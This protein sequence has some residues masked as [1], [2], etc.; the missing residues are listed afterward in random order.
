MDSVEQDLHRYI[1]FGIKA[2]GGAGDNACGAWLES[3]LRAQGFAV[4][5][6]TVSVPFFTPTR[7]ELTLAG[8]SAPVIPQAIVVPTPEAG[9]TGRFARID[10]LLPVREELSDAIAL[11]DIPRARHSTALEKPIQ[12]GVKA[13]TAKGA[14]AAVILTN[15]PT[16]QAV[17]L[18]ADGNKPMF[19]IPVAV[20]APQDA[21][22][23]LAAAQQGGS[24]TLFMTG[25]GGRRDAFNLS[26]R[27]DRGKAKWIVVSTPRSGWFTCAGERGPGVAVWLALA[28]WAPKALPNHN[29]VFVANTAHEYE[30]LGAEQ[31]LQAVAPKPEETALWL[32]LGAAI[33]ARDWHELTPPLLPLPNADP[34][35]YL[36]VSAD[37]LDAARRAFAGQPGIEAPYEVSKFTA[38]ELTPV[39]DAG[40]KTLGGFFGIH[41]FHH[42]TS[43]DARCIAVEPTR[44]AALGCQRLLEALA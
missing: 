22:A 15:G 17:A 33:A 42:T 1:D 19:D 30:Y 9:V 25:A 5:R 26:G 11:I 36:V 32:A 39:H 12:A 40:Y 23:F 13:A 10:P 6:Q 35:R 3:E 14:R 7:A 18:N 37:I 43:D 34:Q 20:L 27:L 8:T 24:G 28:R 4:L 29:L 21:P 41:R 38:G 16:D 2:S 44:Q 31:A